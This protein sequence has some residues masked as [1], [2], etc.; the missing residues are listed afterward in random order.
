MVRLQGV[1]ATSRAVPND[2]DQWAMRF[3]R[4]HVDLGT[5]D[6]KFAI[7]LARRQPTVG[8]VAVDTCLDHLSGPRRRD[9]ENVR[10]ARL[11]A[12]DWQP[13]TLPVAHAV[14][15][16]FPYGSL[17]RGLVEG[18][19]GLLARLDE[20]P[21]VGSRLEVR[22]NES[23]LIATGLDPV[24]GPEAIAAAVRQLG[25]LRVDRRDLGQPELRAFPSSWARRLGYGKETWAWLIEAMR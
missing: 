18:D 10:F 12:R 21:G 24:R 16:N 1:P 13:G 15:I 7:Q 17:L 6:G 20:L 4:R 22:V 2:L 19:A 5:G 3:E 9:P 14:T 8:V 11:D 23:A 25:G